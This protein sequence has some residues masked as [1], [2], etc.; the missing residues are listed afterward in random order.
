MGMN[1]KNI[2]LFSKDKPLCVEK[3]SCIFLFI[4]IIEA[5]VIFYFDMKIPLGVAFGIPYVVVILTILFSDNKK[6]V[7]IAAVACT[8][9]TLIGYLASPIGGEMWKVHSNRGLAIF[10]IWATAFMSLFIIRSRTALQ[11]ERDFANNLICTAPIIILFLD[12]EGTIQHVNPCFERLTGYSLDEIIGKKWFTIMLPVKNQSRLRDLFVRS[13]YTESPDGYI[14]PIITKEGQEYS[15]EWHDHVMR[16]KDG[17]VT[18]LLVVGQDI[19]ERRKTESMLK[20][21]EK[22]IH[23]IVESSKDWIW[24]IDKNGNH[25]YCNPAVEKIL[26]YKVDELI[27]KSSLEF[28][29]EED[30]KASQKLL[31]KNDIAKSG[32]NNV[33]IRW[34]HKN[35]SYRYLESNAVP[36]LD[37][38]GE[39]IGYRGVDR[40]ITYRIE[41]RKKIEESDKKVRKLIEKVDNIREEERSLISREIHDEFGQVLTILK[42]D[43]CKLRE[44]LSSH[45]KEVDQQI[46]SM[47]SIV[48]NSMEIARKIAAN[49]RPTI[50]YDLGLE[51]A[52]SWYCQEIKKKTGIA[53]KLSGC[54]PENLSD[55]I[56]TSLFRIFQE[57]VTNIVRH[58]QTDKYRIDLKSTHDYVYMIIRDYG[59]G[60]EESKII[61]SDDLGIL[62]M[63]ERAHQYGGDVV[64]K[65]HKDGGVQVL[66]NMP[67][68]GVSDDTERD[69]KSIYC[70]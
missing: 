9:L 62:G 6:A 69:D 27:G 2:S 18:G 29:H 44:K 15:I 23:A 52:I 16:N 26:G 25:T 42:I 22:M 65:N 33:I 31:N 34:R 21:R 11:Y 45:E 68:A 67:I 10:A 35:S 57:A 63:I 56:K 55:N 47:L 49:L 13:E 50:L 20:E 1:N 41:C 58:S 43:L 59:V 8:A 30:S 53:Y 64:I 51:A 3:M 24:S 5:I 38:E 60:L 4:G 54:V 61:Q 17:D 36:I 39:L 66:V 28:M 19:T 7:L 70:G 12:R 37:A 48:D 32:W 14:N 40:D 46:S